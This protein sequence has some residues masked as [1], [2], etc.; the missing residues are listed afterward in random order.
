[1]PAML[2]Q[3][4]LIKIPE[5]NIVSVAKAVVILFPDIRIT[6]G[7]SWPQDYVSILSQ[8]FRDTTGKLLTRYQRLGFTTVGI[9][10]RDT[11]SETFS[12]LYPQSKLKNIIRWEK[13]CSDWDNKDSSDYQKFRQLY[14]SY[15]PKL[16]GELNLQNKA[17]VIVGGYH[18]KDCV[19]T[20]AAYLRKEGFRTKV[21]LRLTDELSFLLISHLLRRMLPEEMRREHAKEDRLLWEYLKEDEEDIIEE[22]T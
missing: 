6:G 14:K 7:K 3:R 18:A 10:Y 17:E 12:Y 11:T 19:A 21:D 15:M 2:E 9:I 5:R 1:M 16:L 22:Q 20:F 8:N 13:T 4:E